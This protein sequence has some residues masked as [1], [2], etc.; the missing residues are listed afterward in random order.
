MTV[1]LIDPIQCPVS[2]R[3]QLRDKD[4]VTALIQEA[5]YLMKEYR[6]LM[7]MLKTKQTEYLSF[8]KPFKGDILFFFK[9]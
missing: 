9:N 7:L 2:H 4:K 6:L 8:V 3:N 1:M 5:L